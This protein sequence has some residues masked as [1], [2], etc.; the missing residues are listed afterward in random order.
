[1][2]QFETGV[3]VEEFYNS[4]LTGCHLLARCWRV[5]A[6]RNHSKLKKF[7]QYTSTAAAQSRGHLGE[8]WMRVALYYARKNE[9]STVHR[10]NVLR[11]MITQLTM[12]QTLPPFHLTLQ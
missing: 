7:R 6:D 2:F 10:C 11:S 9:E 5:L 3:N 12:A 1:M 4:V 8:E